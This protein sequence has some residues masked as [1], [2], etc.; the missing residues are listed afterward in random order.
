[1]YIDAFQ[2]GNAHQFPRKP[3]IGIVTTVGSYEKHLPQWCAGVRGLQRQPDKVVIAA[4]NPEVVRATTEKELPQ[5]HIVPVEEEFQLG[6]YLN[7]AIAECHTDWI[8]WIG[9]D[10]RYRPTALNGVEV[11]EQD[12]YIYGMEIRGK[13]VWNGGQIT[14]ALTYNP[15]PC[16]SPFRRWI[17]E[18]IPFQEQ[19][20]PF[21]DWAFWV[22]AMKLGASA[23]Q[24]GRV[25]FFY[26]QHEDQI[27]PSQEPTATRIREWAAT[28]AT[29]AD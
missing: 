9:A 19:L 11:I 29:P 24:T 10:D 17:W 27:V 20:A 18:A 22:G 15:A 7:R 12:I 5:A 28:L 21:E 26:A 8:A 13:G 6:R 16:G 23:K 1:M 14:D 2:R 3:T 4:H 25:D